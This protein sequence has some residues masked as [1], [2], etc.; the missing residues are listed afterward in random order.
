MLRERKI[1]IRITP[2]RVVTTIVIAA[3]VVNLIVVGAAFGASSASVASTLTPL[4]SGPTSTVTLLVPSSTV[5]ATITPT[6]TPS[7]S[8]TNTSTLTLTPTLAPSLAVC[9]PQYSWPVYFTRAG[10]TLFSLALATGSTVAEL[11]LANCLSSDLIHAGQPLYVPRLPVEPPTFT[12]VTPADTPATPTDTPTTPADTPITPADTPDTPSS[13]EN[14]PTDF[15]SHYVCFSQ[16]TDRAEFSFS[17]TPVDPD[18]VK[19]L[20]A[21]FH[22]NAGDQWIDIPMELNGDVY[23]GMVSIPGI[24][25]AKDTIFYSFTAIDNLESSTQADFS[26]PLFECYL[27]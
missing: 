26:E 12:P 9:I 11:M 20:T 25:S 18:L 22:V 13:P 16:I 1:C 5:A 10:D 6:R 17:V 27:G 21:R 24:Y 14:T 8:A 7:P 23:S 15:G 4:L 2:A 19:S 3:G